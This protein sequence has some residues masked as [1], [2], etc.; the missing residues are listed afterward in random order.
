M[1]IDTKEAFTVVTDPAEIHEIFAKD[2]LAK[3]EPNTNWGAL[4]PW[5]GFNNITKTDILQFKR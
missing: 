2:E 4:E 1:Q 5:K 3:G